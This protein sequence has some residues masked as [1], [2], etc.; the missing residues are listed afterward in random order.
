[1]NDINRDLVRTRDDLHWMELDETDK[2]FVLQ[3]TLESQ[4]FSVNCCP[5][6][7]AHLKLPLPHPKTRVLGSLSYTFPH[8]M[9]IY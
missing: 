8:L 2:L 4:V 3:D 5:L 7:L 9:G 6:H 1:M